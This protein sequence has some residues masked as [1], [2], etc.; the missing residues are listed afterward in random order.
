MCNILKLKN[1]SEIVILVYIFILLTKV[2]FDAYIQYYL[3][4]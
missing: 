1:R 2:L 3:T 4:V